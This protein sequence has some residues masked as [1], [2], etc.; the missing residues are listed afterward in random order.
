MVCPDGYEKSTQSINLGMTSNCQPKCKEGFYGSN[1][2]CEPNC[3]SDFTDIGATCLK[4]EPYGRGFDGY[5]SF[6][7]C[8][9]GYERWGA[10]CYPKCEK[11][12]HAT[13]CCI[14]SPDCPSDMTDYGVGCWKDKRYGRG[15]GKAPLCPL[16]THNIEGKCYECPANT[17]PTWNK[18]TECVTCDEWITRQGVC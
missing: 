11:N 17:V 7:A 2:F 3:P 1:E 6:N 9:S 8:A 18:K 4:P 5:W 14:C 15:M 16:G 10:V 13:A 12:F